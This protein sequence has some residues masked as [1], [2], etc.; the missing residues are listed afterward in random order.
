MVNLAPNDI[1]KIIR[2]QDKRF[3]NNNNNKNYAHYCIRFSIVYKNSKP[4]L[5]GIFSAVCILF[6]IKMSH[7]KK[8]DKVT[9]LPPDTIV[10]FSRFEMGVFI[11][12]ATSITLNT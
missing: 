10:E 5:S 2:A 7:F 11:V 1:G 6:L 3:N 8:F 12:S 4:L 9:L